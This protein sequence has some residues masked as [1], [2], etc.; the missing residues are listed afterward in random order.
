MPN[1]CRRRC[2]LPRPCRRRRGR[3]T[4][5]RMPIPLKTALIGA[6][7]GAEIARRAPDPARPKPKRAVTFE[8][9]DEPPLLSI[10]RGFSAP[11][12]VEAE[13]RP[14]ELE[15]LARDRS[16][17]VRAL[18]G[19]AGAD[20]PRPDRRRQRR[21]RRPDAGDRR[22]PR[23]ADLERA[24][25]GVQGRGADHAVGKPDRRPHG[26]SS[27]R[28]PST[29]PRDASA[30]RRSGTALRA[31]LAEAQAAGAPASELSPG[32]QGHQRA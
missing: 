17:P 30:G 2:V 9:V 7:S 22:D 8:G 1:A 26:K 23:H 16:R 25:P 29:R 18:R 21:A 3:R 11:V 15:R 13:R 31:E 28:T 6:D 14:G 5:S 12:I 20:A 19:D 27:I 4:S 32:R 24:R 10:N